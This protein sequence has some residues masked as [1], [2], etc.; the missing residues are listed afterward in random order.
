MKLARDGLPT[1]GG[2]AFMVIGGGLVSPWISVILAF[3]MMLAI[4]FYRDPERTPEATAGWVSPADGKVVEIEEVD[5][6]YTGKATKIGIFMNGLDVHVNRFPTS[7]RVEYVKYVP[8]KKWFAIAP[9]ASEI[10][11]RFYVGA[12]SEEGR[13]LLVQIAGILARRIVCRVNKGDTLDRGQRYGMIKLGSKVD[14]YLPPSVV[15]VV[16]IDS[17]VVAGETVIGVVKK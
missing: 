5:H 15:P 7:G 14:V 17:R 3:P 12:K 10:N 13:F 4:W 11:E 8:G 6:E 2:L 16:K 9:K 1:I